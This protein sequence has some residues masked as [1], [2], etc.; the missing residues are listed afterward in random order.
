M[1]DLPPTTVTPVEPENAMPNSLHAPAEAQPI[2]NPTFASPDATETPGWDTAIRYMA[3]LG[4]VGIFVFLIYIAVVFNRVNQWQSVMESFANNALQVRIS[5]PQNVGRDETSKL[6]VVVENTGQETFSNL[7]LGF[8]SNGIARFTN[9][10][11][12]FTE[13]PAKAQRNMTLEYTIDNASDIRNSDIQLTAHL[14]Y[15]TATLPITGTVLSTTMQTPQVVAF[16]QPIVISINP[17]REYYLEAEEF[18][19][20]TSAKLPAIIISIISA[21]GAFVSINVQGGPAKMLQWFV[22]MPTTNNEKGDN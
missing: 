8:T 3:Y 22:R 15:I 10:E 1:T 6:H 7:R 17:D 9:S 12:L 18:W 2:N 14:Y 16:R 5:Y 19:S 20:D 11:A 4:V 21:I 13:L